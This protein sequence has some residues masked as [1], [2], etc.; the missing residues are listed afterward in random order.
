MRRLTAF[1]RIREAYAEGNII[2]TQFPDLR[3]KV[4]CELGKQLGF[5]DSCSV[6][7]HLISSRIKEPLCVMQGR[8]A[9]ANSERYGDGSTN[10][11]DRLSISID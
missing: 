8:D 4:S 9:S 5:S 10:S 6:H 2:G 7:G 1:E 11:L 3:S